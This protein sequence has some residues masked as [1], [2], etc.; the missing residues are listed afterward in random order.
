[1]EGLVLTK[2][3]KLIETYWDYD[4]EKEEG[5]YKTREID[6]LTPHVLHE[7]GCSIEEGTTLQNLFTYLNKDVVAWQVFIGNWCE[8]FVKE[9]LKDLVEKSSDL[10]YL[11]LYWSYTIDKYKHEEEPQC[12]LGYRMDFH[13]IGIPD[14]HGCD[15]YSLSISPVNTINSIPIK[16]NEEVVLYETDY[17]THK[18]KKTVLGKQ[19][20]TLFQIVYGIIWELSFHGGPEKRDAERQKLNDIMVDLKEKYP[21]LKGDSDV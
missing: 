2:D 18:D 9:G 4:D 15:R 14:E 7:L 3:S 13:A 5:Q 10:L 8:E 20:P 17:E 21:E 6:F 12:N 1:M 19:K 16:V 11:E